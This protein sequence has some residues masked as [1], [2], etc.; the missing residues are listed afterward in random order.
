MKLKRRDA[1]PFLR[2]TEGKTTPRHD[3]NDPRKLMI[4]LKKLGLQPKLQRGRVI[5]SG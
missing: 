1:E 5:V 4:E 3:W 2:R